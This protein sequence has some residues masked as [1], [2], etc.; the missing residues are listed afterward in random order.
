MESLSELQLE[1]IKLVSDAASGVEL[2]DQLRACVQKVERFNED[3]DCLCGARKLTPKTSKAVILHFNDVY[4]ISPRK[5]GTTY[6]AGAARY[7]SYVNSFR[8]G[9]QRFK[10]VDPVVMFSGDAFNPSIESVTTK[11]KHMVPVL[12]AIG[13]DVAC[14]GNHDFDFGIEELMKLSLNCKFPWLISNVRYKPTQKPLAEGR[15]THMLTLGDGL[16]IGL[17]GLVEW[18]WMATLSTIEEDE[19]IYDDFVECGRHL[20]KELRSKGAD[21]VIALTHMR[22]PNDRRLAKEAGDCI[23]VILGGHDHDYVE[24]RYGPHNTLILKSGT[25]FRDLTVLELHFH[26]GVEGKNKVDVVSHHEIVDDATP[27]D[28]ET[29]AVVSE[30]TSKITS[31][32]SRII[33]ET[34]V[35]L[36]CRFS[37]IRCGET[38]IANFVADIMRTGTRADIAIL[39]AGTLR[40]D[41][42]VPRG[43]FA[44]SD[45]RA[46]LPMVDEQVVIEMNGAQII[47][48]LENGVSKYPET[49]G[50]FPCVSGIRFEF[51]PRKTP[52]SRVLH[53]SITIGGEPL[54]GSRSYSVV[55]KAYL[56]KGKDG[57]D[58]FSRCK[59]LVDEECSPNLPTLVRYHFMSLAVLNGFK[60]SSSLHSFTF[61][62]AVRKLQSVTQR[63]MTGV[64]YIEPVIDGRIKNMAQPHTD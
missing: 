6:Y 15:T 64:Y 50:R 11:G 62:K 30:F 63:K 54:D 46:L 57:Y 47:L 3:L 21:V 29:K 44:L 59:V 45:L 5:V 4:N 37:K 33:G 8:R 31:D 19:L 27:E 18:A 55:T 36:D 23:D 43:P 56:A 32:M 16:R 17:I 41:A 40:M 35:D 26:A 58:V 10:G 12:N 38:N 53:D 52:G 13:V 60:Q 39:N 51:D 9:G 61:M 42:I 7:V 2:L 24:E 1:V 49:E 34:A 48:A 20:S 22:L 25:D 14:F 28:P